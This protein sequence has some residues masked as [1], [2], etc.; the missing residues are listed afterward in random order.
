V[1][2]KEE[3]LPGKKC[4]LMGNKNYDRL[5]EYDGKEKA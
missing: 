5:R 1:G 4:D 2:K 3:G